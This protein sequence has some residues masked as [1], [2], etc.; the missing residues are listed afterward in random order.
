MPSSDGT[1]GGGE[2]LKIPKVRVVPPAKEERRV[3]IPTW[4]LSLQLSPERLSSQGEW[5]GVWKSAW[6]HSGTAVGFSISPGGSSRLRLRRSPSVNGPPP[7]GW[8]L[9]SAVRATG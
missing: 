9:K 8:K 7:S 1:P 4:V 3:A 2:R 6:L 5:R